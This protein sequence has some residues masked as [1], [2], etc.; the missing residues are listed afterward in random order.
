MK[1][2]EAFKQIEKYFNDQLSPEALTYFEQQLQTDPE[3]AEYYRQYLQLDSTLRFYGKRK[4]L[5]AQLNAIH[6]E[7]EA[8]A[9]NQPTAERKVITPF[10]D[11]QKRK[12]FWHQHY[13][14][15]AV[16]ASV[17]ILTVFGTLMSIDVWRSMGKQQNARYTA[18]RREVEKIK[19]S[20][21]ALVQGYNGADARVAPKP[22]PA[23]FSGTGFAIS[24]DGY[25]VTSYHVVKDADSVFIEN[26]AGQRFRV[27]NIYR[28]QTHDL[29]I[30][31]IDDADFTSFGSLPYAFK[32]D[33]SELGERVYTLGFPR[34]DMVF[35]EG[36]LSSKTGFEGD[37]TSYQISIPLN[38]GNSGGPLLDSQGN[39]IGIISGQQLDQQGASF[40][41]KSAYL[42]QLVEQLS[43]D[44]LNV[45]IKLST[46]NSLSWTSRPEQLK[47]I[48]DYVF[49]VK[50]YNN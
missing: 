44:S 18:L 6:N 4:G 28:D 31:K 10:G 8:T 35:G 32:S 21:R 17:A 42:K 34:E 30:L 19:N 46:K 23:N 7:M 41:V 50:V 3:M 5:K 2:L 29:A 39:L 24:S 43:Q 12:I 20:Q 14:T 11:K 45:P 36:S 27:K 49:M 22:L 26:R 16:A 37:T 38:P 1:E 13:A 40:A 9:E 47:K 15:I 33:L 25:L 48:K